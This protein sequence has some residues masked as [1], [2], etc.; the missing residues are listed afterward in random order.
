[1]K[2]N[3]IIRNID[4]E[5]IIIPDE[6]YLKKEEKIVNFLLFRIM[7]KNFK[8]RQKDNVY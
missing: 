2:S 8:K 5:V 1:L 4:R 7:K 3:V 6:Y